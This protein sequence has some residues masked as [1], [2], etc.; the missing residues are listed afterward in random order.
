[1][2][3]P[4]PASTFELAFLICYNMISSL[5]MPEAKA[6]SGVISSPLITLQM[7]LEHHADLKQE[8]RHNRVYISTLSTASISLPAFTQVILQLYNVSKM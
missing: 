7:L 6:F 4:N 8:H 2:Y 1:M 5:K 3:D